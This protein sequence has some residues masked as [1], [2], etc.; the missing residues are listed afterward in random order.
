VTSKT[1]AADPSTA[2]SRWAAATEATTAAGDA[3]NAATDAIPRTHQD[4]EDAEAHLVNVLANANAGTP[5]RAEIGKAR[6]AVEKC[7]AD[8]EWA[9]IEHKAAEQA[10]FRA[11]EN[12]VVARRAVI[13]EEFAAASAAWNDPENREHVLRA[14]IESALAELVVLSADRRE[15]HGRL[16]QE[17]A[18]FPEDERL[19]LRAAGHGLSG[20]SRPDWYA[21][22]SITLRDQ[23]IKDAIETGLGKG[24]DALNQRE[25]ARRSD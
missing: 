23:T 3:L 21:P 22:L 25:R 5:S 13:A 4:L 12:E 7:R 14:Q 15:L 11:V 10:Y 2:Q 18:H 20:D 17:I 8:I 16:E 1:Q 9:G 6:T 19:K 24:K